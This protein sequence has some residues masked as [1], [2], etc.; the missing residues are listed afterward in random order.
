VR[1]FAAVL[2]LCSSLAA[3]AQ[4]ARIILIRH[5]E[6]PADPALPHLSEDGQKRASRLARWLTQGKVLGTNGLPG[7]LFA[8]AP[9]LRG[10]SLRCAETLQPTADRLDLPL[11]TSYAAADYRR[12]AYD[13]LRDRSLKG[14]TVVIC[15]VHE[16]LPELAV[17]LGVKPEPPKW[18]DKDFESAY[19]ITFLE[20][21][22]SLDVMRQKFK[23]M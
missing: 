3:G 16:C 19:V 12:L 2:L 13:L 21:Q 7:A 20:G 23:V 10:R 11:R 6:K 1:R 22:A 8:A 4:P 18:K 14:R 15:W 9:T 17:A 5:A